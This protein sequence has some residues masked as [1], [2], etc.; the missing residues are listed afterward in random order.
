MI[1]LGRL[2]GGKVRARLELL[3]SIFVMSQLSLKESSVEIAFP[4]SWEVSSIPTH[5]WKEKA[6]IDDQL[7]SGA[8]YNPFNLRLCHV[9]FPGCTF[10]MSF[11]T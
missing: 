2:E 10:F 6:R 7:F 11:I 8:A 1:P 9:L 5:Y 3:F 4:W